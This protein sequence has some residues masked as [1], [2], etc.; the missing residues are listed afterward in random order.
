MMRGMRAKEQADA[1]ATLGDARRWLDEIAALLERGELTVERALPPFQEIAG[2]L[3]DV[4][5]TMRSDLER[6]TPRGLGLRVSQ[7]S[8][9]RLTSLRHHRA[10]PLTV[11]A[12]YL[13]TAPPD[14]APRI[15]MVTPT[16]QQG[17]F[18]E[19]TIYSVVSQH[20][21]NLEYVVQDGGST[22]ETADVLRRWEGAIT[23]IASAADD[24]QADALNRG[25]ADTTG[26]IMAFLNSDDLLLPGSL[27]HVARQFRE[28]PDVDVIYGNRLIIDEFDGRI[29]AHVLPAHDDATL[30][31]FDYVPQET[32]F[33]R[34]SAWEAAGGHM[35]TSFGF[36]L[37]WDLL[38]R[39]RDSGARMVHLP[40]YLG[41]FR[42]HGEQKSQKALAAFQRDAERLLQRASGRGMTLDEAHARARPYLRRHVLHHTF[43]RALERLPLPRSRV[44]TLPPAL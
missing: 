34:R 29:G 3:L 23:R 19:R 22:D 42:V 30:G 37:D 21:P 39:L 16:Y 7:W 24:G 15:T 32:L 25:F 8:A 2:R 13:R 12:H 41:A 11:P 36:A 26:E 17:A 43:A 1:A 5:I 33:W 18:L 31:L 28:H 27:A 35:D 40:R 4:E 44:R 10:E 14:P 38:L 20:Y 6:R 9:P